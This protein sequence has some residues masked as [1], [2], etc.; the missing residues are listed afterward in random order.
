MSV[1]GPTLVKISFSSALSMP[2]LRLTPTSS[3]FDLF[4]T[5]SS[6]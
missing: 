3:T 5:V 6:R 1:P 4:R 2:H